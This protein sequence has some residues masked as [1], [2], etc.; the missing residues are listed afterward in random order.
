MTTQVPESLSNLASTL[1]INDRA[2]PWIDTSTHPDRVSRLGTEVAHYFRDEKIDAVVC[3]NRPDDAVVTHSIAAAMS[4]PSARMEIDL[5]IISFNAALPPAVTSVLAVASV[6]TP[7]H[8]SLTIFRTLDNIGIRVTAFL[9]ILP[10]TEDP[11]TLSL[12]APYL[13]LGGHSDVSS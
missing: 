3:W 8:P 7:S 10:G 9:S 2:T 4:A 6:W 1:V 13:V 5:G 11:S 12:G